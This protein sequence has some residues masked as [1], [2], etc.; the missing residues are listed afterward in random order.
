M[1]VVLVHW[2][3]KPDYVDEFK[4]SRAD[5]SGKP[6]FLGEELY[7][8]ESRHYGVISFLNVGR[9]VRREDFYRAFDVEPGAEIPIKPFEASPRTREWLAWVAIDPSPEG[10]A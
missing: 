7:R 2:H 8:T 5:L 4:G 6:G 1:E 3:I 9:W 10:A